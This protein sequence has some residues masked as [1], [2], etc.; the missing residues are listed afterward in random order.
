MENHVIFSQQTK[1]KNS[2][3]EVGVENFGPFDKNRL[4]PKTRQKGKIF[5]MMHV[6]SHRI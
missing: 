6:V 4:Q 2:K 5:S 3:D 1:D